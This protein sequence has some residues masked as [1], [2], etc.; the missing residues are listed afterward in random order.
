V[1]LLCPFDPVLRDRAR[2][3][4]LFNFDFRFEGFVP[5]ADRKHGYYVMALLDGDRFVGKADP[6]FDRATGTLRVHKVWWEQGLRP[7]R[8]RLRQYE[9]GLER[10]AGWVGARTIEVTA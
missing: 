6:K 2:A 1:R 10:L 5:A 3:K 8:Q 7:K 9:A 4:R